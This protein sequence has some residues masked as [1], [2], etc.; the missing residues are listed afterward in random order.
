MN[1]YIPPKPSHKNNDTEKDFI[2]WCSLL[3]FQT[4]SHKFVM[5]RQTGCYYSTDKVL[6]LMCVNGTF[7]NPGKQNVSDMKYVDIPVAPVLVGKGCYG[8]NVAV[9]NEFERA[10]K[11]FEAKNSYMLRYLATS[12]HTPD[13][14]VEAIKNLPKTLRSAI[15]D[16]N[17]RLKKNASLK[18][19]I[20]AAKVLTKNP[21]Y[22]KIYQ[23]CL[24]RNR[25]IYFGNIEDSLDEV[26]TLKRK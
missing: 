15:Y 16:E 6:M 9:E 5:V 10:M 24:E 23:D 22:K 21:Q 13:D 1:N 25:K 11:I 2:E 3:G 20:S 12:I 17:H 4:M 7:L 26:P 8:T 18:D 14:A 19:L